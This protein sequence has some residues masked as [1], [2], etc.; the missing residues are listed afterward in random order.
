MR[1]VSKLLSERDCVTLSGLPLGQ[2]LFVPIH[3]GILVCR[4]YEKKPERLG[5]YTSSQSFLSAIN[6]FESGRSEYLIIAIVRPAPTKEGE[7]V[8]SDAF[9]HASRYSLGT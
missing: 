4:T 9:V 6:L 2:D 5:L 8:R 7:G 1:E 3:Q